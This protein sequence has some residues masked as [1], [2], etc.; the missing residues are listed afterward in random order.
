MTE[1]MAAIIS[2]FTLYLW[3]EFQIISLSDITFLSWSG[4]S[5]NPNFP[6]YQS[7]WNN[8]KFNYCWQIKLKTAARTSKITEKWQQWSLF[9]SL[10]LSYNLQIIF[11]C[12]LLLSRRGLVNLSALALGSI[13]LTET[14]TNL[15][16]A[17][18]IG[19]K[20]LQ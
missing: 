3:Y 7:E 11:T 4:Q 19:Q 10:Y 9:L 16:V 1:K 17:W 18:K 6:Q 20:C 14:I 15:P 8:N 12:L 13:D 5:V 2:F